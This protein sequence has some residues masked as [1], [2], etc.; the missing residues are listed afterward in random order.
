MLISEI[1]SQ[2]FDSRLGLQVMFFPFWFV[3]IQG[4]QHVLCC[5]LFVCLSVL[6]GSDKAQ[7]FGPIS[8]P[9]SQSMGKHDLSAMES[10]LERWERHWRPS[11]GFQVRTGGFWVLILMVGAASQAYPWNGD[12]NVDSIGIIGILWWSNS[13]LWK[14]NDN[15]QSYYIYRCINHYRS[16]N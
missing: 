12:R 13:L 9:P 14:I 3:T 6:H 2:A 1:W 8:C 5:F 10:V 15:H 16:W 7:D 11:K 4:Y